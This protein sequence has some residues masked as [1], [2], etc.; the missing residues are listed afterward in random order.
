M[1]VKILPFEICVLGILN[2]PQLKY[3]LKL[4]TLKKGEIFTLSNYYTTQTLSYHL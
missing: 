4:A 1:K 3:R 2:I